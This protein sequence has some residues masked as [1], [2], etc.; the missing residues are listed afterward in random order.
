[1]D[2]P[3]ILLITID[4]Q[5]TELFDHGLWDRHNYYDETWRIPLVLSMR[6]TLPHGSSGGFAL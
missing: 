5:R 6:G 3:N 4:T 1:M 2:R